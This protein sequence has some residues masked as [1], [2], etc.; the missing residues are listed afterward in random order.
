[1]GACA[2]QRARLAGVLDRVTLLEPA[3]TIEQHWALYGQLDIALDT[4]PYNGTTTTCEALWM[5]VPV[6]TIAGNAHVS[7]VSTS[8]LRAAGVPELVARDDDDFVRIASTL[9]R[10]SQRLHEFRTTLRDRVASSPLGDQRAFAKR[11]GDALR[12]MWHVKCS[13]N[14]L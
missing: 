6:V 2:E 11:F 13:D 4:F 14:V 8:L 12:A 3:A 5:G 10:D 1:V 7:R 9:A